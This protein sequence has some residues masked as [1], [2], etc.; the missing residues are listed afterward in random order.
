VNA[1]RNRRSLR[2]TAIAIVCACAFAYVVGTSFEIALVPTES[3]QNTV[4]VGDHILVSKLPYGPKLAFLNAHVPRLKHVARGELVSFREQR[5]G[6][7]YLKRVVA[8]GGDTVEIRERKLYVNGTAM[9]EQYASP[10]R[11][12]RTMAARRVNPGEIF[13]LGDNRDHSEDSRYF[14]SIPE[15]SVIGSPALVLWSYRAPTSEWLDAHGR[16]RP[17]AYVSAAAHLFTRTRWARTAMT[18]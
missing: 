7:V 17:A 8:V 3:M 5:S 11:L 2:Q 9:P 15:S 6:L 14:G 16:V 13:V 4:L 12:W 1:V 18:L 10:S